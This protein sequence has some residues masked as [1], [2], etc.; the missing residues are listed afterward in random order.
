MFTETQQSVDIPTAE[1][2]VLYHRENRKGNLFLRFA[3]RTYI[4]SQEFKEDC[5]SQSLVGSYIKS[6]LYNITGLT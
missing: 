2:L 3:G 5:N 6:K 4:A 1:C